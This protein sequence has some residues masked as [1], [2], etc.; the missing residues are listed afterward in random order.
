VTT[1]DDPLFQAI[2]E[3]DLRAAER[4]EQRAKRQ[5]DLLTLQRAI[6][7][8]ELGNAAHQLADAQYRASSAR[9]MLES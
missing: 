6:I 7:D 4:D 1:M 9:Q 3:Q 2:W 5:I 8:D